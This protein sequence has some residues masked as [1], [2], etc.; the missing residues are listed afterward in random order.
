MKSEEH[1][2]KAIE[3][4]KKYIRREGKHKEDDKDMLVM[5]KHH[6]LSLM[7]NGDEDMYY[8]IYRKMEEQEILI[9]ERFK[10]LFN[11]LR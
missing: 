6:V 11:Q 3:I 5:F 8:E 10:D 4:Y 7:M 9:D 1:R 2:D